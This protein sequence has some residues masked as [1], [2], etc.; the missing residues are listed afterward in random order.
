MCGVGYN[1]VNDVIY[2]SNS[3]LN[4]YIIHLGLILYITLHRNFEYDGRTI[5]AKYKYNTT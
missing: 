1:N 3:L 5:P 2:P 4:M